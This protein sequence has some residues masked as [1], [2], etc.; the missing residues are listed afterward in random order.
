MNKDLIL[1]AAVHFK[2]VWP[3]G[4]ETLIVST[5]KNIL[6][7][8]GTYQ[9]FIDD[10][11]YFNIVISYYGNWEWVCNKQEFEDFVESLFDGAPD[12]AEYYLHREDS[13]DFWKSVAGGY[14][15]WNKV[16]QEWVDQICSLSQVESELIRRPHKQKQEKEEWSGEGLPP[17]GTECEYKYDFFFIE[18]QIGNCIP[19]AYHGGKVWIE[20]SIDETQH[21]IDVEKIDFR[22]LKTEAEKELDQLTL[23]G[24]NTVEYYSG[25]AKPTL[26]SAIRI[27]VQSGWRP[28]K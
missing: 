11:P 1:K 24:I 13:Y 12:D 10:K 2:G 15:H 8:S 17:V 25:L 20:L 28:T 3:D 27:L 14:L 9:N 26:E 22:P 6:L 18:R 23:D 7:G 5:E 16:T 19:I 21:L 4:Y